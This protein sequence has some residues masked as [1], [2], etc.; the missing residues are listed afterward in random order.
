MNKRTGRMNVESFMG[1][2]ICAVAF[3][4]IVTVFFIKDIPFALKMGGQ[5]S[6]GASLFIGLLSFYNEVKTSELR[7]AFLNMPHHEL[8]NK[9]I[10]FY[11]GSLDNENHKL[12]SRRASLTFASMS[13]GLFTASIGTGLIAM[14]IKI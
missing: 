3:L 14:V 13:F 2:G 4:V 6:L 10:S 12:L 9:K 5:V 8:M 11:I 7:E 1:G